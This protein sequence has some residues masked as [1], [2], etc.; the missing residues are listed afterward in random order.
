MGTSAS[1]ATR[2][3]PALLTSTSTLPCSRIASATAARTLSSD[4]TSSSSSRQPS[5]PRMDARDRAVA[6][7]AHLAA[8][9]ARTTACP[10]PPSEHPVTSTTGRRRSSL[11]SW[12]DSAIPGA[13]GLPEEIPSLAF[14]WMAARRRRRR[15][16]IP[17]GWRRRDQ[18]R[19]DLVGDDLRCFFFFFLKKSNPALL[20]PRRR[21]FVRCELQKNIYGGILST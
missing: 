2:W 13:S 20:L 6:T 19:E 11:S 18:Q 8:T 21:K 16:V 14:A 12:P 7:T 3:T 1:G 4:S 17:R 10:M 9:N 15:V 5:R